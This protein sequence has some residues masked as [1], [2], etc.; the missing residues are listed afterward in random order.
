MA[1][2]NALRAAGVRTG[3]RVATLP[4]NSSPMLEAHFGVPAAGGILVATNNRLAGREVGHILAHSGARFLL[5]RSVS[6]G[7]SAS[8]AHMSIPTSRR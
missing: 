1:L 5:L 6:H 4:F 2:A 3:D 7:G 8:Q